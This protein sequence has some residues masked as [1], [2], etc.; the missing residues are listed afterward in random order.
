MLAKIGTVAAKVGGFFVNFANAAMKYAA[1][2]GAYILG[3]RKAKM[4]QLEEV[5]EKKDE[6]LEIMS[7][8]D[9]HRNTL[10]DR[11]RRRKRSDE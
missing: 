2:W 11:M 7:K 1:V 9:A 10:L 4:E 5:V 8:P 6:Q 3:K